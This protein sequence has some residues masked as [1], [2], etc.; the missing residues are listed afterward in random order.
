LAD[1]LYKKG[2]IAESEKHVYTIINHDPSYD[3]WVAKSFILLSDILVSKN[4]LFQ[5]KHTLQSII[6]N[7]EGADLVEIARKKI[8]KI[9][10]MEKKLEQKKVKEQIEIN[11]L[12]EKGSDEKLFEDEPKTEP[13]KDEEVKYE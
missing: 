12:P 4:D 10:E 6:D 7:Y 8:D 1:L 13:V 9:L 3:L 5:A 2:K 11:I